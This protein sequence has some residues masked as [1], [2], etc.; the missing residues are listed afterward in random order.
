[1]T[2][3]KIIMNMRES[4]PSDFPEWG[5]VAYDATG[6]D[7]K[8]ICLSCSELRV[9][10]IFIIKQHFKSHHKTLLKKTI[11]K[12]RQFFFCIGLQYFKPHGLRRRSAAARLLRSWARIQSR[13]WKFVCCECYVL[14][15]RGLCDELITRPEGSYRL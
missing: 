12:M 3:S 5:S 2:L 11:A 8:G 4:S 1:M 9:S 15:G 7:V 13:T 6:R 14:S 10:I